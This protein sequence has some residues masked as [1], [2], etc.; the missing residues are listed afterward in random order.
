M[1]SFQAP[2]HSLSRTKISSLLEDI[3]ICLI[4]CPFHFL[5]AFFL[6]SSLP[7][8]TSPVARLCHFQH[9]SLHLPTP[10]MTL[11]LCKPYGLAD[12]AGSVLIQEWKAIAAPSF[13]TGGWRQTCPPT[14]SFSPRK[15][16]T[17]RVSHLCV[18]SPSSTDS[19]LRCSGLS[20]LGRRSFR[21]TWNRELSDVWRR[22]P[23]EANLVV[24][25]AIALG[26]PNWG[27]DT[28]VPAML[29]GKASSP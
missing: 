29:V 18:V 16:R 26:R 20:L 23:A 19:V 4:S 6:G 21:Q 13:S 14:P 15:S 28:G 3:F 25:L 7:V 9:S 11:P 27:K 5:P 17:Q 2:H 8:T 22:R 24:K 1:P 10:R 12:E